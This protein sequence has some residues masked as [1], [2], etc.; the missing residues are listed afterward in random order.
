MS[1]SSLIAETATPLPTPSATP[2]IN[3]ET[4]VLPR[5]T[6]GAKATF[7]AVLLNRVSSS[8]TLVNSLFSP[9]VFTARIRK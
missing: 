7:G 8:I 6:K 9:F 2:E 5:N 1:G 4:N 3:G